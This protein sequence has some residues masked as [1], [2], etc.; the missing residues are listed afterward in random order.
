MGFAEMF[1]RELEKIRDP[2]NA[3]FIDSW[4]GSLQAFVHAGRLGKTSVERGRVVLDERLDGVV[5]VDPIARWI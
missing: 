1:E 5:P 3:G 2:A 4:I